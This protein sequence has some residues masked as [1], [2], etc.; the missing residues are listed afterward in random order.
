MQKAVKTNFYL[1]SEGENQESVEIY[2]GQNS[3]K[4]LKRDIL[5]AKEE[6]WIVSPYI[7]KK[8]LD[9]L[10]ELQNKG[11]E[12]KLAFSDL[13][14]EQR[15]NILRSLIHQEKKVDEVLKEKVHKQKR[16]LSNLFLSMLVTGILFLLYS[17]TTL[18]NWD[19]K[20][21]IGLGASIFSFL[22]AGIIIKKK[23]KISQTPVN[24]YDYSEKI[25]F[26]YF[27]N[28][29]KN[30]NVKFIHSKIYIIDRKIAY[31]GSLN[32]TNNGFT[33]NF[34]TRVRITNTE[35][36]NELIDFVDTIFKDN[37]NFKSHQISFLGKQVYTEVQY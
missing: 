25:K 5:N 26:K 31:V 2:I 17:L 18:K 21:M 19:Y 37:N 11:V 9:D 28:D 1:K 16:L 29:F 12:I 10:I 20:G 23:K 34:E 30:G 22:I 14:K 3:G 6:V 33:S 13:R 24:S 36:L 35:K 27:W 15:N 32:F 8:N 4:Q 7:D